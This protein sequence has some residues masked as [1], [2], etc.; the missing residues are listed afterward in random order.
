M[1]VLSAHLSFFVRGENYV[2]L[3]LGHLSLSHLGWFHSLLRKD[4]ERVFLH[5]FWT[6]EGTSL[7]GL[8]NADIIWPGTAGQRRVARKE[9]RASAIRPF[10]CIRGKTH[11][12]AP[13]RCDL[14][15][16]WRATSGGGYALPICPLSRRGGDGCDGRGAVREQRDI[17]KGPA[18]WVRGSTATGTLWSVQ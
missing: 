7:A 16:W 13:A 1:G 9:H 2:C 12:Q 15:R 5:V 3:D 6:I 17:K 4:R 11:N 10:G 8:D 18:A 14:S